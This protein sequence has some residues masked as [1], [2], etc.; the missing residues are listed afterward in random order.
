MFEAFDSILDEEGRLLVETVREFRHK[1][2]DEI[3]RK[4][5]EDPQ[6]DEWKVSWHEAEEIGL[7][8][9]LLGE[10]KG[11]EGISLPSLCHALCEL[12]RSQAGFTAALLSNN[13]SL[14]ALSCAGCNDEIKRALESKGILAFVLDKE[15]D[16]PV[17]SPGASVSEFIVVLSF[18]DGKVGFL[19]SNSGSIERSAG[20]PMGL[21]ASRPAW[22]RVCDFAPSGKLGEE[23]LARVLSALLLGVASIAL[24]I[25]INAF[26]KAHS[27]A[28]QRYQGG[29][30]IIRHEQIRLMLAEMLCGIENVRASISSASC[31]TEHHQML[32]ISRAAKVFACEHAVKCATDGVQIHGGYGY[33]RDYGM[34]VLMRDAKYLQVYPFTPSEE[35]LTVPGLPEA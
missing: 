31:V 7:L 2:I 19:E 12:A 11:G 17:F 25:S 15:Q 27:Y 30:I 18:E 21:R 4:I 20:E 24:G 13:I 32:T 23:E 16:I 5:D 26:E 1:R 34:E 29:D 33:M 14:L 3:A 22:I 35:L 10:E 6:A 28:S 8:R 9:A